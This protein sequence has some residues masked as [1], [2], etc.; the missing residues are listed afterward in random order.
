MEMG[1]GLLLVAGVSLLSACSSGHDHREDHDNRVNPAKAIIAIMDTNGDNQVSWQENQQYFDK[2][3]ARLDFG[4]KGYVT[5]AEFQAMNND[6]LFKM[7]PLQKLQVSFTMFD[8]NDDKKLSR[9]EFEHMGDRIFAL[10]DR[11]MDGEIS[12]SDFTE[13]KESCSRDSRQGGSGG[14]SRHGGMGGLLNW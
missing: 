13:S 14:H 2:L 11:N 6:P 1:R 7:M 10:L 9:E 4:K 12:E 8:R 3:F 5:E